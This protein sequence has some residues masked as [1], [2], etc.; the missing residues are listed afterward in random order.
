MGTARKENIEFAGGNY[1]EKLSFTPSTTR[2]GTAD[3][4][5]TYKGFSLDIEV[6]IGS[7]KLSS[8]QIKEQQRIQSAGGVYLVAKSMPHF[9]EQW[10]PIRRR[11]DAASNAIDLLTTK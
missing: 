4:K 9:L 7:D 10:D 3:I 8:H 5:G 2:K 1:R 6:K 11:L